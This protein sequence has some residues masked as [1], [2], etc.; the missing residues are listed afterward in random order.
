MIRRAAAEDAEEMARLSGQLGYPADVEQMEM[1]LRAVADRSDNV[2]YVVESDG[3]L[4]GWVH[5]TVRLSIESES[6]AEIAG[7]VV[8]A[9]RRRAGIGGQLVQACEQW[10]SEAGF[11]KIRVRTNETRTDAVSFYARHGFA[12]NK[13]QRVLDKKV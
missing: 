2:V 13:T 9:A 10:A 6:Y 8:D 4:A 7:L 3:G 11:S 12:W 5:A 1:R